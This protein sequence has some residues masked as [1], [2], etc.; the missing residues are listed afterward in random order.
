MKRL[1]IE[2][3]SPEWHELR[4][5]SI[6]ASDCPSIM[7]VGYDTPKNLWKQ[8]LGAKKFQS[9][10]M[11]EGKELEPQLR[12]LGPVLAEKHIVIAKERYELA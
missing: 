1:N 9:D 7:G 10:A 8:K 3:D 4:N 11:K 12:E 2:Q 5:C 6:G